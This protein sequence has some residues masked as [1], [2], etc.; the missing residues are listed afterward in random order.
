MTTPSTSDD[1]PDV[2]KEFRNRLAD[3]FHGTQYEKHAIDVFDSR[4]RV[5]MG[6]RSYSPKKAARWAYDEALA[7]FGSYGLTP[8]RRE[9]DAKDRPRLD[10]VLKIIENLPREIREIGK[11][12]DEPKQSIALGCTPAEQLLTQAFYRLQAWGDG[13]IVE[14]DDEDEEPAA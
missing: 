13:F 9:L 8:E 2:I 4:V 14:P 1:G 3:Q 11:R 12:P 6:H 7:R 5:M 10:R